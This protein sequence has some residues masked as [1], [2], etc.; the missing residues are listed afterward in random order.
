MTIRT[1]R[2]VPFFA[3]AGCLASSAVLLLILS[4]SALSETGFVRIGEPNPLILWFEVLVMYPFFCVVGVLA[5][6]RLRK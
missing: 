1:D 6:L 5:F 4:M 2:L 3:A